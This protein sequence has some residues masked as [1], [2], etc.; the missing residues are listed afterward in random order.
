MFTSADAI[1][2]SYMCYQGGELLEEGVFDLKRAS[3]G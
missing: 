2:G 1:H 3:A